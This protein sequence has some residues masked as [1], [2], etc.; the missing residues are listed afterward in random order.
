MNFI[1]RH[2][3]LMVIALAILVRLGVLIALPGVFNFGVT[4]Q[5]HGSEAYDTYARNLLA[6]GVYGREPGV[7]D[8]AIPPLYSYVLA[9]VYAVF[10]RGYLQVGGF[11]IL[12]DALSILLL[13][14]VGK[15][16]FRH[17]EAVGALAGLFYALYPY[18]IFQ[19]LTL[20]DT[21]LFMTLLHG[22]VLAVVLLRERQRLD[23]GAWM[24]AALAGVALGL[25]TLT[26][27]VLPLLALFIAI[28]FLFRLN[29]RQTV[30]RLAPVALIALLW[31]TPWIVRNEQV[32][33]AFV[34]MSLTAGTNLFQG[35]NAQVVPYMQAG[36]DPQWIGP[37]EGAISADPNSPAADRQR[38]ELALDYLRQH[39]ADIPQLLWTKF[40]AHWSI[41]VF[42]RKNPVEG[43]LPRLDYQGN[44]IA[45][46]DTTGGVELGGLPP[47]DA[48][49]V[50]AEPLF[51]QIGRIVHRFYFGGLL[52][53]ALIGIG[54]SARQW[55][56]VSLLWAVQINMTLVYVLFHPSTRY[57]VPSDPLLFLFS[58]YALVWLWR[59]WRGHASTAPVTSSSS[60]D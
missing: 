9:G 6:T 24:L 14:Q 57:R 37:P 18:L 1:L 40:L 49:G 4:G 23:G 21:P 16:L 22:F 47:G 56:E 43:Q 32:Y 13:F 28:W 51:D 5:I 8:A 52:L 50:Y 30:A 59:R 53:L 34:P 60:T 25:A 20:I 44:V 7:P 11:H 41:D 15:H 33:H 31:L 35:N 54:L 39:P 58:A 36:Y 48:V 3:L 26:R 27:P 12:L 17:G 10:G 29:L 19:N 55:R 46:T 38:Y 2:K 45:G 42:P